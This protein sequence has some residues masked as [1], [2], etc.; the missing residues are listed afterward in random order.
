MDWSLFDVLQYIAKWDLSCIKNYLRSTM[1]QSSLSDLTLLSIVS[2]TVKGIEFDE[3]IDRFAV[4]F[5][6]LG[7][8]IRCFP[9]IQSTIYIQ[10]KHRK[11]AFRI[12]N[13]SECFL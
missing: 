12:R 13:V 6:N 4:Y 11:T 1:R 10:L 5:L 3:V 7:S 2:D 8:H 9:R